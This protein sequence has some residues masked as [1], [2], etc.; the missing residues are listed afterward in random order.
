MQDVNQAAGGEAPEGIELFIPAVYDIVWS[1]VPFIIILVFF[2]KFVI[3]RFTAV[4]DDRTATIEGGIA[5]A[6]AAQAEADA[7]LDQYNTLLREARQEAAKIREN[8]RAEGS[9]IL[10]EFKAD[11]NAEAERIV[12]NAHVQIEAERQ[13]ALVSVRNELG[14]MAIDLASRVIGESLKDDRR[15]ASVVDQFISGLNEPAKAKG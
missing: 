10:A 12:A 15:S 6:E 9:T 4:M 3:P 13:A 2:W 14:G 7:T 11:A 5:K 8:A 1:I